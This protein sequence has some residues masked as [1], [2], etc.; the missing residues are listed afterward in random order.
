MDRR[1]M[2]GDQAADNGIIS[3]QPVVTPT[4]RFA[5][6]SPLK[7]RWV[8]RRQ[9]LNH[10]PLEGEGRSGAPGWGDPAEAADHC[11]MLSPMRAEPFYWK[12]TH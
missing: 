5:A 6:T 7:G 9:R 4:R 12:A 1:K 2:A 10:P 3:I 11:R 8:V